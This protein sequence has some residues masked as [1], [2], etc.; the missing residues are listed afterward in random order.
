MCYWGRV[1]LDQEANAIWIGIG[2]VFS[3]YLGWTRDK[4]LRKAQLRAYHLYIR[5]LRRRA[6]I[7]ARAR[8]L[9]RLLLRLAGRRFARKVVP[10]D[11]EGRW[12]A[13]QRINAG[14]RTIIVERR[15]D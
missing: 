3:G 9:K 10:G 8:A 6:W 15:V 4:R 2:L 5:G 7:E 11:V 14:G 1:T 13:V 12:K